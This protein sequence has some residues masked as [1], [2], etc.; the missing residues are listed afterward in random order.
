MLTMSWVGKKLLT[1]TWSGL[2][3]KVLGGN[4]DNGGVPIFYGFLK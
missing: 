4:I 2:T 1:L 3:D